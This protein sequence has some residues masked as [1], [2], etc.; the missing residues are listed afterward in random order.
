MQ[1]DNVYDSLVEEEKLV[2]KCGKRQSLV[3]K[4][5][6]LTARPLHQ[7]ESLKMSVS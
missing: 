1:D 3:L 6:V 2:S 5:I 4:E 7:S